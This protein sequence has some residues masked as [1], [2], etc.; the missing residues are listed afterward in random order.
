MT[1]NARVDFACDGFAILPAYLD[2]D[3]LSAAREALP[4]VFPTA[5]EFHDD[6][7]PARNA[8]FRDEFGGI[9]NFP[10]DAVELNLVAVHERLIDLAADLL[11]DDDLRVYSIEAWAKYTGAAAYD[12][13]HHRDYLSQSL[14]VP[15]PGAPARQVEMFLYLC[16]VPVELGPPRYV[17]MEHTAALPAIPN[18]YPRVDAPVDPEFPTWSATSGTPHL[19]DAEVAA[20]GPAGTVVAYR[21]DTFHRGSELTRPRGAR[22][23]IHLNFRVAAHDWIAR[24]GW[25]DKANTEPWHAF[26][27]RATPKQLQTFGFPPPGHPYWTSDTLA[28]MAARYAGFDPEPWRA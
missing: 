19:Y 3:D 28:G 17:P 13:P 26:V 20:A 24:R 23:T 10:F 1:A 4:A 2:D 14:L 6:V 25:T 9:T 18:W 12:Q 27:A 8:R 15:E 21:I 5:D 16:D 22:Y 7:D 11:G